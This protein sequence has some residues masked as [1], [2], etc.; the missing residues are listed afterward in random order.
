MHILVSFYIFKLIHNI[1]HWD[2][3]LKMVDDRKKT[4]KANNE[5]LNLSVYK[6]YKLSTSTWFK[7]IAY[8]L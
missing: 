4:S 2:T 6:D 3:F 7:I 1:L 5:S 8:W